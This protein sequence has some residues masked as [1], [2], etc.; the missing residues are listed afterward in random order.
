[1]IIENHKILAMEFSAEK[2]KGAGSVYEEHLIWASEIG[3]I[4]SFRF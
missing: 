2:G 1:M 4:G 3:V